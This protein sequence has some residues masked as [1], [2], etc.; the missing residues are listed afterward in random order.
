MVPPIPISKFHDFIVDLPWGQLCS[1]PC[2]LNGP[3]GLGLS[4]HQHGLWQPVSYA[5]LSQGCSSEDK[6]L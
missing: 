3:L 6:N 5:V 2:V 4:F 1:P